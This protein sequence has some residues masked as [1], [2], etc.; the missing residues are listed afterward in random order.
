MGNYAKRNSAKSR[1]YKMK[2]LIY[3]FIILFAFSCVTIRK[4]HTFGDDLKK[5]YPEYKDNSNDYLWSSFLN[6]FNDS[7]IMY[8]VVNDSYDYIG[9]FNNVIRRDRQ[10]LYVEGEK[11]KSGILNMIDSSK[12][13]DCIFTSIHYNKSGSFE[14][15][16]RVN[17]R[18]FQAR[19]HVKCDRKGMIESVDYFYYDFENDSDTLIIIIYPYSG[20]GY[21]KDY[22][23][24]KS[25][26]KSFDI[27]EPISNSD[28]ADTI[29]TY[30]YRRC[31]KEEGAF[32]S[33][34]R[35]GEWKFY[36]INGKQTHSHHYKIKDQ[37][38]VLSVFDR[39]KAK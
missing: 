7:V 23:Y 26:V 18:F 22:Y 15:Y 6:C 17:E 8:Q 28:V 34:Y 30:K 20:D 13:D 3:L 10:Y 25:G 21:W 27:Y 11:F 4:K 38:H 19:T 29:I 36:D 5:I 16:S 24:T 9:Q 39:I 33:S 2:N 32:K 12:Y 14:S 31:L 1:M 35:Y 37:V